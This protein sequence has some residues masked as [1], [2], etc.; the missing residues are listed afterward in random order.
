MDYINLHDSVIMYAHLP[1]LFDF[2]A[3]GF[4]DLKFGVTLVGD[5]V[6][7]QDKRQF[8]VS[9]GIHSKLAVNASSYV[10]VMNKGDLIP[11]ENFNGYEW[12][13]VSSVL[14][15][16]RVENAGGDIFWQGHW[17]GVVKKYLPFQMIK[18]DRRYNGWV[19]LTV[20][21]EQEK[22]VL[23]RL[24]LCKEAEEEIAAG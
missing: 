11:I 21:T 13:L 22:I 15:V 6:L 20:N 5:P 18:N 1:A 3:D 4:S 19:E 23:H 9:S 2:D 16:E 8:T 12:W 10:P 24:A 14:L 7:H 17:K